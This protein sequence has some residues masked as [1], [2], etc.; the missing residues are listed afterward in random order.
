MMDANDFAWYERDRAEYEYEQ[1][2]PVC[3]ECGEAITDSDEFYM[4]NGDCYCEQCMDGMRMRVDEYIR[5][6]ATA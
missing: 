1:E 4:V 6:R 2:C 3:V 5:E